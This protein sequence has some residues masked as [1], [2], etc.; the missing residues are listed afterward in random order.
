MAG[1]TR[2]PATPTRPGE[3]PLVLVT[4]SSGL[5]GARIVAD[6]TRDH[7]V[8]GLDVE[9]PDDRS[10]LQAFVRADLTDDGSVRD[11]LR[12]VR[13]RCGERVASVVHLAAYY[14]FSGAP[15][16]LYDE[17]TVEGTRRLLQ[18]LADGFRV[19]QVIFSSS[20]LVMRPA[21]EGE[22]LDESCAVH[23]EWDY[24][25]SKLAA[26]EV[27]RRERRGAPAV[28]LRIAGVYDD[29]GHSIPVAQ[30]IWRIREKSFQSYFFPGDASHGQAFVHVDDVVAA[31][32]AA[33]QRRGELADEEL[34]LIAE[35]DVMSYAELQDALG[36][37]LHGVHW[38]ALRVPAPLAKAGAWVQD[39]LGGDEAFIKPWMIDLADAHYPVDPS[40]ARE[41]L[42]WRPAHRLRETLPSM[43][44]HLEQDPVG[45]YAEHDLPRA[46]EARRE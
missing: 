34:F 45:W 30:Q 36:E 21:E 16:P 14:D 25:S 44:H 5:L 1:V 10:A 6:L 33:I 9:P 19:E 37:L 18:G 27:L 39:K 7:R 42:G 4:G 31:V 38:P 28:V 12:E 11:A 40:R 13:E 26:E 29:V 17:L 24:P 3:G 15:S 8:V 22:R 23:A 2:E 46:E 20:L 43:V 35:P 32:R 41:R